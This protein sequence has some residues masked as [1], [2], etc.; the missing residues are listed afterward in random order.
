MTKYRHLILL[1]GMTTLASVSGCTPLIDTDSEGKPVAPANKVVLQQGRVTY[2]KKRSCSC[3]PG[4]A[5]CQ[6]I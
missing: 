2:K 5:V 6:S 3:S 4:S 1:C